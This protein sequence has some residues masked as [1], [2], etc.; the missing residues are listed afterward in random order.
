ML[1]QVVRLLG[2]L[3]S[4]F[5]SHLS[6]EKNF[7]ISINSILLKTIEFTSVFV[8][9]Q[10]EKLRHSN[11]LSQ[12]E[13][14]SLSPCVGVL[15]KETCQCFGIALVAVITHWFGWIY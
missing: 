4:S 5:C 10:L 14:G 12:A 15:E 8:Q 7:P 6:P 13:G 9:L 3:F 1:A 2:I 11:A